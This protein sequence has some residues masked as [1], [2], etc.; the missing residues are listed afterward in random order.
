MPG[1]FAGEEVRDHLVRDRAS[2]KALACEPVH[3]HNDIRTQLG[4]GSISPPPA[5][6]AR[7]ACSS[8]TWAS[9]TGST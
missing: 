6:G 1:P 8:P 2:N 5:P 3:K 9:R 4:Q 7:D